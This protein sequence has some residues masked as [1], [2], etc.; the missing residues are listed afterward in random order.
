MKLLLVEDHLSLAEMLM[1]QFSRAGY[2]VDA[3]R[4]GDQALLLVEANDYDAMLLDLGLPGQDGMSVLR[5]V[6]SSGRKRLPIIVLTARDDIRNRIDGLDAGADD[7][8]TK[9]F[10]WGELEARVRAVLRRPSELAPELFEFGNVSIAPARM[11]V[12]V[13]GRPLALARR[14]LALLDEL[15]RAAPRILVRDR[16]E[17]RLY[18]MNEAVTPNA[19]EAIAS[20]LRKSLAAADADIRIATVRG[21]GYRLVESKSSDDV[22]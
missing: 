22:D 12:Q 10:D 15:L 14:E 4:T 2:T 7:Y 1:D 18:T 21:V 11:E 5:T 19:I 9:P 6:R 13:G 17:D 16:L 20:R 8:V 3:V